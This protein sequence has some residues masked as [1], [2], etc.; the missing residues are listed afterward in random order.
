MHWLRVACLG[1]LTTNSSVLSRPDEARTP[2]P[3]SYADVT[4]ALGLCFR[5]WPSEGTPHKYLIETMG[6]GVALADLQ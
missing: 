1:L 2:T 3:A 4:E 6:A 5:H